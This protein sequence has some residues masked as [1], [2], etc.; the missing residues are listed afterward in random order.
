MVVPVTGAFALAVVEDGAREETGLEESPAFEAADHPPSEPAIEELGHG[1]ASYYGR[2]FEGRPTASGE[3]FE[4]DGMTA[5]HR[6]L[7][8]GTKVRVTSQRTGRS[9][10]VR[11]NDRGPFHKNRLIDLSAGAAKRIGLFQRGRGKVSLTLLGD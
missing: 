9:V 5:A 7:P 11:I 2:R 6:T 4:S 8:F 10:V 1:E 3:R